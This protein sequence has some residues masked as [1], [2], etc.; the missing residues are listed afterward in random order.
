M[1]SVKQEAGRRIAFLVAEKS[2]RRKFVGFFAGSAGAV[3]VSRALDMTKSAT[4]KIYIADPENPNIIRGNG[5]KFSKE[6]VV[7]GLLVLPTPPSGGSA[8]S[9]EILE[10]ISDEEIKL[11]KEF[12]G[13]EAFEQLTVSSETGERGTKFKVAAKVDQSEVYDTVFQRLNTGGCVGIFPEGGSHDRTEL[14]P[15]KGMFH[16]NFQSFCPHPLVAA[17]ASNEGEEERGYEG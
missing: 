10:I 12:K 4:G 9:A 7:G 5:T 13:E 17:Y 11:K 3:P 6:A 15:L 8:A 16:K 1:R 14:L 2:M